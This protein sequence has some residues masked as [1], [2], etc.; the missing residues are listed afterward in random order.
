M[1]NHY[2][3]PGL[4]PPPPPAAQS[5]SYLPPAGPQPQTSDG[6]GHQPPPQATA[7]QL[8][9]D[10]PPVRDQ[11]DPRLAAWRTHH[12]D[13]WVRADDLHANVRQLIDERGRLPALRQKLRQLANAPV[14]GFKLESEVRGNRA[15][16]VTY[17]RLAGLEG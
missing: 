10:R 2:L 13:A 3:P 6:N 11:D 9:T 1:N 8:P 7:I 4:P 5:N 16:P 15:K 17:Y 14:G 12:A